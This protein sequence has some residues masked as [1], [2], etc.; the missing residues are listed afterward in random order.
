MLFQG[1]L[2]RNPHCQRR[3]CLWHDGFVNH[4]L[5]QE[6]NCLTGE[7]ITSAANFIRGLV[8]LLQRNCNSVVSSNARNT[9]KL[10]VRILRHHAWITYCLHTPYDFNTG[11]LFLE[12]ISTHVRCHDKNESALHVLWECEVLAK[13]L[14]PGTPFIYQVTIKRF[15]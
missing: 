2:L 5:C 7:G 4:D 10:K 12:N 6:S 11:S 3:L 9:R 8:I 14:S 15:H 1:L 13:I